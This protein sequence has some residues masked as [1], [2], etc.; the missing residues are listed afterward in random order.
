MDQTLR[1]RAPRPHRAPG[2]HQDHRRSSGGR[3]PG[4]FPHNPSGPRHESAAGG[5]DELRRARV[6][7]PLHRHAGPARPP[8]LQGCAAAARPPAPRP[9]PCASEPSPHDDDRRTLAYQ[10]MVCWATRSA[11][12]RSSSF[13]AISVRAAPRVGGVQ[14]GHRPRSRPGRRSH[15]GPHLRFG[16]AS[17]ARPPPAASWCAQCC[18]CAAGSRPPPLPHRAVVPVRPPR[19]P[20]GWFRRAGRTP[21]P[22]PWTP[23]R[24]VRRGRF[25]LTYH[26]SLAWRTAPVTTHTDSRS[27]SGATA[28]L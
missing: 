28:L 2:M 10:L 24:P 19:P 3:P 12:T 15:H 20:T 1:H 25:G 17:A 14:P 22:G 4:R 13:R 21:A 6:P 26:V 9:P 11:S 23:R 18:P 5:T 8:P 7:A 27:G 16:P